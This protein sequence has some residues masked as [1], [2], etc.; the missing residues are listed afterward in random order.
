MLFFNK[1]LSLIICL[2]KNVL[3]LNK[4]EGYDI[5][6][7]IFFILKISFAFLFVCGDLKITHLLDR[8]FILL[9][10]ILYNLRNLIL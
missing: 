1:I 2:I 8:V 5:C 9:T 3:V 6:F 10:L 7:F 4:K